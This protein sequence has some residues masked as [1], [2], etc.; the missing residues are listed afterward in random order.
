M[1]KYSC[2]LR[3]AILL[4]VLSKSLT[5]QIDTT[6]SVDS[7]SGPTA[8]RGIG[9]FDT[10]FHVEQ[11]DS[12]IIVA[13]GSFFNGKSTVPDLNGYL[14]PPDP[15]FGQ[16]ILPTIASN[17]LIGGIGPSFTGNSLLDDGLDIH[18][19]TDE[20]G[21]ELGF[22]GLFGPGFVGTSFSTKV[23]LGESGNIYFAINDAP[24]DDNSGNITVTI[25]KILLTNIEQP[26][27]I[28]ISEFKLFQNYPNPFN[29]TTTIEFSLPESGFSTLVIYNMMGQKVRDLVYGDML[30]GVH[31][32]LWDG[33]NDS[34]ETVSSGVYIS[35]LKSGKNVI[36][37]S[38]LLMK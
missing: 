19:I 16:T 6:I 22:P 11:G 34:G 2:I 26:L 1:K 9:L 35:R 21:T 17:S 20:S 32:L 30:A 25:T 18:P 5:A 10:G 15:S 3:V 23:S 13:T 12:I 29:P 37:S 36:A 27:G 31:S 28:S 14:G 24:L 33:K 38:M 4:M 8:H 7:R